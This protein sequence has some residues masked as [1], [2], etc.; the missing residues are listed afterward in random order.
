MRFFF[1]GSLLDS[2][3]TALVIGRRLPPTAWV[4]ASLSGHTRSKAKGVSYPILVRDPRGKAKGAVVVGFSPLEVKRLA[5]YEGPRYRI[6]PLKVKIRGRIETVSVFEPIEK[7]FEAV[8]RPW[9]LAVW[10]RRD[11]RAFVDR[12]RRVFSAHPAYSRR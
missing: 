11:K 5:A 7:K 4:P 2:D 8:G 12:I 6:A 9:S 3:V 10:Q 1:Y